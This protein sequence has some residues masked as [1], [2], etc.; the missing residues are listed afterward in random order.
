MARIFS[1]NSAGVAKAVMNNKRSGM[2]AI[3]GLSTSAGRKNA[4]RVGTSAMRRHPYRTTGA[5]IVG[6]GLYA[7]SRVGP[8]GPRGGYGS[9]GSSGLSPRSSGG[10]A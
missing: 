9:S 10:Y 4:M 2:D 6:L 3:R 1:V 7:N 8:R 5:G